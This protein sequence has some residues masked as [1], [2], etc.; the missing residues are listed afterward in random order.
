MTTTTL[1]DS[2]SFHETAFIFLNIAIPLISVAI[3]VHYLALV[4]V[5]R[6]AESACAV[7]A[8]WAGVR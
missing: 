7:A 3:A 1:A 5:L 8:C 6:V 4:I 2:R